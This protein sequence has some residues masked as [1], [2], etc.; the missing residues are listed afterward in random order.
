[1]DGL[2]FATTTNGLSLSAQDRPGGRLG[3]RFLFQHRGLEM[4]SAADE[5]DCATEVTVDGADGRHDPGRRH[6]TCSNVPVGISIDVLTAKVGTMDNP[7]SRVSRV[8]LSWVYADWK[9]SDA[10]AAAGVRQDFMLKSTVRFVEMDQASAE[11]VTPATPPSSVFLTGC[12]L[13]VPQRGARWWARGD[14]GLVGGAFR[15]RS[16]S[17]A[18]ATARRGVSMSVRAGSGGC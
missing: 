11:G 6:R 17:A 4:C 2:L 15:P 3:G 8:E 9:Y 10:V 18:T 13:S 14:R 1:M 7:Q 12:L 5:T 16:C